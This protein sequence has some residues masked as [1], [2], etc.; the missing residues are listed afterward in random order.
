MRETETIDDYYDEYMNIASKINLTDEEKFNT[1][2]KGLLP[3]YQ[4]QIRGSLDGNNRT[5]ANALA[6]AQRMDEARD[7]KEEGKQTKFK[8]WRE[9]LPECSSDE[10]DDEEEKTKKIIKK[11]NKKEK[12]KKE[13]I[14]Q[15]KIDKLEKQMDA[16]S[17]ELQEKWKINRIQ[18]R[19]PRNYNNQRNYEGEI[20][21]YQCGRT[22]HIRRECPQNNQNR[23][24]SNYQNNR[25]NAGRYQPNNQT[26][27]RNRYQRINQANVIQVTDESSEEE[28]S[29]GE[30]EIYSIEEQDRKRKR[31][32]PEIVFDGKQ[33]RGSWANKQPNKWWEN[34]KGNKNTPME[35]DQKEKKSVKKDRK[36]VRENNKEN[37]TN[38]KVAERA[39]E[40]E[41]PIKIKDLLKIKGNEVKREIKQK[42]KDP[43]TK[44]GLILSRKRTRPLITVDIDGS[45][46]DA[47]C[48][49]GADI[50]T[51]SQDV[52]EQLELQR[53][54]S[55][56]RIRGITNKDAKNLG[57]SRQVPIKIFG[58]EIPIDMEI[59]DGKN[60]FVLGRDWMK[61]AGVIVNSP[62][63]EVIFK[64]K[65][66]IRVPFRENQEESDTEEDDD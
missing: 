16:L 40:T 31:T 62:A 43:E 41:I 23:Y 33:N 30:I 6:M 49:T 58:E 12:G 57:K 66:E 9:T 63:E 60:L 32:E 1:F 28:T 5:I 29:D 10:E 45:K 4:L 13:T 17:K 15:T 35:I 39:L 3:E 27:S 22:G 20:Q 44:V 65:D 18:N 2:V 53:E 48:D 8:E 64:W 54:N 34:P 55:K 59:I 42:M 21:C 50:S 24:Q 19:D 14:D 51:M 37:K 38:I 7:V 61:I 46:V 11:K 25:N 52:F 47:L 36:V 56:A 26:N